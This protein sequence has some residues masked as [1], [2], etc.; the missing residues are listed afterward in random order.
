[1]GL[2]P[3]ALDPLTGEKT[4]RVDALNGMIQAG[5]YAL[6]GAGPL[7]TA[8]GDPTFARWLDS[9]RALGGA[10]ADSAAPAIVRAAASADA[11]SGTTGD[12]DGH[13]LTATWNFEDLGALGDVE[14]KSISG[15]RQQ[16]TRNFGDLDGVDNTIAPGRRRRAERP[17]GVH[18]VP[19][20]RVPG[21]IPGQSAGVPA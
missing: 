1:M 2:N 11:Y 15:W 4:D 9:A 14:F 7:A 21:R 16:D 18:D 19:A 10:Y 20:L 5:D 13:S 12:S 6:L 8:A 3:L 17:R